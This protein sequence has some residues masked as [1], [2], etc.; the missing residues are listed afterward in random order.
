[1]ANGRGGR[2]KKVE[3][4]QLNQVVKTTLTKADLGWL[5]EQYKKETVGQKV[6]FAQYLRQRLL[7]KISRQEPGKERADLLAI[8]LELA[9]IREL[10][11]GSA[12]IDN[13]VERIEGRSQMKGIADES[14]VKSIEI[15]S[16]NVVHIQHLSALIKQISTW[17]YDSLPEK[18]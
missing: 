14:N 2:A 1:M 10:L 11:E 13:N 15:Q 3:E 6:S 16:E 8:Q 18:I 4:S 12:K 7:K 9:Q 17:L 5:E